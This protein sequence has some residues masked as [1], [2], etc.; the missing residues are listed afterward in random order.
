MRLVVFLNRLYM[1]IR[2]YSLIPEMKHYGPR[3]VGWCLHDPIPGAVEL[4]TGCDFEWVPSPRQN[5]IKF[6]L[7][8]AVPPRCIDECQRSNQV[9]ILQRQ[10]SGD[11]PTHGF[12]DDMEWPTTLLAQHVGDDACHFFGG[13]GERLRTRCGPVAGEIW[14]DQTSFFAEFI[15]QVEI[16]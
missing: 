16:H 4:L 15:D 13:I 11:V 8:K 14:D 9:A 3:H 10:R 5:P 1:V 6:A 2:G 7:F 12:T